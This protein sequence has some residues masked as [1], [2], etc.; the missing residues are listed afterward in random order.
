MS[1]KWMEPNSSKNAS[2]SSFLI[3]ISL[4]PLARFVASLLNSC[5][6]EK[7]HVE[8]TVYPV[9]PPRYAKARAINLKQQRPDLFTLSDPEQ[10]AMLIKA[11]LK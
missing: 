7:V 5:Q 2:K 9:Q 8:L 10:I 3:Q 6:L 1:P 11:I 4:K